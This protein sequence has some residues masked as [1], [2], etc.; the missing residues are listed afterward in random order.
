MKNYE[1]T[2]I[3]SPL[4]TEEETNALIGTI[5]SFLQDQGGLLGNQSA[6]KATRL[7]YPIKKQ[8]EG[9]VVTLSFSLI[10]G[11][12]KAV[13]AKLKE[14][15][16]IMRFMLVNKITKAST[17]KA[18]APRLTPVV[19]KKEPMVKADAKE[20]DEKLQEIFKEATS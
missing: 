7:G 19:E 11:K 9:T 8:R 1:L 3:L 20:I 13:E 17:I 12:I 6:G 4:L 2:V 15:T 16:S 10:P 5:T 14:T 18:T